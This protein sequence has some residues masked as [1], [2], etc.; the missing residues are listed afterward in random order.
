M[1][2]RKSVTVYGRRYRIA[3]PRSWDGRYTLTGYEV[4]RG[5]ALPEGVTPD[6]PD[7]LAQARAVVDQA[8]ASR[9]AAAAA[10]ARAWRGG[11]ADA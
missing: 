1:S 4:G 3:G 10:L 5:I 9:R 8:R 7:L 2:T 6:S 11:Q